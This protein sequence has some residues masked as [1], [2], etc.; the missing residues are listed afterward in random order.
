MDV[1]VRTL[2]MAHRQFVEIAKALSRDVRVLILDEPSVSL[3]PHELKNLFEA[4]RKLKALGV[5]VI[6]ISHRL[7]EIFE[8]GDRIT[9]L[10]DGRLVDSCSVNSAKESTL[11]RWM[12]G[13][14]LSGEY[15]R[16]RTGGG[17]ELL[18]LENVGGGAVRGVNL[19]LHE[20]EVLGLG[21]LVGAGRT[22]IARI[23][24]GADPF[25]SG[26]IFFRGL[27]VKPRSP[28]AAIELGIGYLSEDRNN[29]GL[30]LQMSVRENITLSSLGSVRRG[31]F[32]D[33]RLEKQACDKFIGQLT[34]KTPDM[35]RRAD[36]LSGGNRQKVI[37]ARW[38]MT[39]SS[40][41]I[42]DEPTAG[43]D[44]G[45]KFEIYSLIDVLAS[46]GMGIIVISSDLPELLGIS[47]RIAVVSGGT[48]T[49][50]LA[51]AGATQERIMELA[52]GNVAPGAGGGG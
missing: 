45:V 14:E 9:V 3:T 29:E 20:G 13:R 31:P 4:I 30:L 23:I 12:V 21:G 18:R 40:V 33:R 50:F 37:L 52:L 39:N 47:D 48:V 28:R 8:I 25:E 26:R 7:E 24:F 49:G 42:F 44:V 17:A 1:P 43:I 27:E 51:G 16:T 41:L 34:I 6:Y 2:S 5:G 32:I 10:R 46:R 19:T 36:E 22:E 35:N 38:L 15:P 11:I